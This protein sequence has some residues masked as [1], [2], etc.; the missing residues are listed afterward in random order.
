MAHVPLPLL[1]FAA[2]YQAPSFPV[3]ANAGFAELTRTD[4]T[5]IFIKL[6]N[7]PRVVR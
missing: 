7:E 4:G 3:I 1:H 5:I 6:P 2:F